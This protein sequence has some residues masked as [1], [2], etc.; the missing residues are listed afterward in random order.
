[1]AYLRV[2]LENIIALCSQDEN[3]YNN[4]IALSLINRC[5]RAL[6]YRDVSIRLTQRDKEFLRSKFLMKYTAD[7]MIVLRYFIYY[8]CERRRVCI[9]TI[10]SR[11]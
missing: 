5:E 1:M 6:V 2:D 9:L 4:P 10:L 11:E 8:I 7:S 3:D